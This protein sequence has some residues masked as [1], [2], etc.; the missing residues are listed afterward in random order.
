MSEVDTV[1]GLLGHLSVPW[2]SITCAGAGVVVA[3]GGLWA[4]MSAMSAY[5]AVPLGGLAGGALGTLIVW[6]GRKQKVGSQQSESI[7]APKEQPEV[8]NIPGARTASFKLYEAACLL[9]GEEPEW[10][11]STQKSREEYNTLCYTVKTDQLESK[12][13]YAGLYVWV[14]PGRG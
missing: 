5:I 13:D 2:T 8:W 12:D 6:L 10:P 7:P 11:L 3:V 14:P 9:V 4:D 1:S